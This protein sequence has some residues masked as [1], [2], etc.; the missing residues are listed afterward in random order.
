[1][2]FVI[3]MLH[4]S[5]NLNNTIGMGGGMIMGVAVSGLLGITFLKFSSCCSVHLGNVTLTA[6]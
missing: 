3:V 2:G 6:V 4:S 1:M 5:Q